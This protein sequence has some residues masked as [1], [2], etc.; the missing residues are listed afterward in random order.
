MEVDRP[1]DRAPRPPLPPR[2][3]GAPDLP[4]GDRHVVHLVGT[5]IQVEAYPWTGGLVLWTQDEQGRWV[6]LPLR[7]AGDLVR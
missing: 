6:K 4:Q 3:S 7:R 5:P 2:R 1:E